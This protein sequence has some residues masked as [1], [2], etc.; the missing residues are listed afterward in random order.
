[1]SQGFITFVQYFGTIF[2]QVLWLIAAGI[3]VWGGMKT[4]EF[5]IEK[6]VLPLFSWIPW[7]IW[8]LATYVFFNNVV[9]S[10]IGFIYSI[11]TS[12][13]TGA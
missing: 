10:V 9:M 13:T 7:L 11:T 6:K 2:P 12:S 5:F 1:M 3:L 8:L 4:R